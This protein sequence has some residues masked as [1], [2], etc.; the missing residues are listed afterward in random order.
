MIPE[1][2]NLI[3]RSDEEVIRN[4]IKEMM[5]AV[6][7]GN[8][9]PV[10]VAPAYTRV[11]RESR[12]ADLGLVAPKPRVENYLRVNLTEPEPS[13]ITGRKNKQRRNKKR[14]GW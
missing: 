3:L 13:G 12:C 10:L 2:V 5:V 9:P 6:D 7:P 1:E 11:L 8:Q 4:K 14:R